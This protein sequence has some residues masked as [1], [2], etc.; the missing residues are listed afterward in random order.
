MPLIYFQFFLSVSFW[1]FFCDG[2]GRLQTYILHSSLKDD[3]MGL[4]AAII[5]LAGVNKNSMQSLEKKTVFF[6][7]FFLS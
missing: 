2:S 3:L 1:V 6:L 4:A 5:V 7:S